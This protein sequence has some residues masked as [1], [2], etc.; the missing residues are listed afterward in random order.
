MRSRKRRKRKKQKRTKKLF[1]SYNYRTGN[2]NALYTIRQS[3]LRG[4][5]LSVHY[6]FLLATIKKNKICNACSLLDFVILIFSRT[7]SAIYDGMVLKFL[8]IDA[9]YYDSKEL[10]SSNAIYDRYE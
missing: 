3:E 10:L 4:T 8:I 5:Y 7:G 6:P 9:I 2:T 1:T